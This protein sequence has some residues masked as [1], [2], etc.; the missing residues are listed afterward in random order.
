MIFLI[1]NVF[2]HFRDRGPLVPHTAGFQY[3]QA[4]AQG[5]GFRINGDHSARQTRIIFLQGVSC[6][7]GTLIGTGQPAGESD[8]ENVVVSLQRFMKHVVK[9]G[10]IDL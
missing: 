2:G 3:K 8:V 9:Y 7:N 1:L 4:Y 6:Q 10:S 5:S